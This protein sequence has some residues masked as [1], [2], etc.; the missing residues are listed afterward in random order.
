MNARIEAVPP[1]SEADLLDLGTRAFQGLGLPAA[2]ARQVSRILVMADL[3]GLGT[4]GL[5]RIESYGERLAVGGINAQPRIT[6]E[7]VAPALSRVNGD[8]AVGPLVGMRALEAAMEAARECGVGVALARASNH[9]GPISPYSLIAAEAG[10]ASIIGSNATTT[11]APWGGSDARLGNSPIGFGVPHP[12]GDPF[13]LDMA[14]SVVARAKIRGALKRG[15]AIPASWATDAQG[16]E[17]TD[18]AAALDGFLLP[19]GG[20]KGYGLALMVDLFAGL[21]SGAAYLTH[22]KSWSQ[23]PEQPQDL[24]HFFILIDTAR[25]GSTEWLAARMRDFAAILHDSPPADPSRPVIVPG[26]IELGKLR[27][28]R[29]SGV[30]LDGA[31][32]QLLQRHAAA[33]PAAAA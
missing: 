18:P 20:H 13:L 25:L 8:N 1:L 4:H 22:V 31:T 3:F 33:A 21:L 10:F 14:M 32:Y 2:D 15:E 16:R 17:T 28:Q 6:V 7:R 29:E 23:A 19:I 27:R 24:G 11:I 26:E 30:T 12:G 9:F 5:S